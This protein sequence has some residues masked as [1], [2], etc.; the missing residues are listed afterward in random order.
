MQ[1]THLLVKNKNLMCVCFGLNTF[2]QMFICCSVRHSY[3]FQGMFFFFAQA[4]EFRIHDGR[5]SE[6]KGNKKKLCLLFN[7]ITKFYYSSNYIIRIKCPFCMGLDQKLNRKQLTRT[8]DKWYIFERSFLF[9]WNWFKLCWLVTLCFSFIWK[10]SKN[11]VYRLLNRPGSFNYLLL[12]V[13]ERVFF[14]NS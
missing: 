11:F 5:K 14:K 2:C 6:K 8:D 3:C 9:S 1:I 12:A 4:I 10:S 13:K 7:K